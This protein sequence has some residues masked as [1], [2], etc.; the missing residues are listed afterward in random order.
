MR[1]RHRRLAVAVAL[2]LVAA[3]LG[4]AMAGTIVGKVEARSP[5]RSQ[6]AAAA[7][8]DAAYANRRYKFLERIDYD[9]LRDF[10]VSIDR[11]SHP[12]PTPAPRAVITQKDGQFSPHVLP[13]VVGTEVEWPNLD[14]IFHNVFSISDACG[15][16]LG[17][18]KRGEGAKKVRFE[19]PGRVDVF[20]SIHTKMSCIVLVLPNPWFARADERGRYV[21][22]DVPPG[23][24]RLKAW[25][26]RLPAQVKEVVVPE[27]G[28]VKVDFT[29][30]LGQQP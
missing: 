6:G 27:A 18:Y 20:C 3:T 28:E 19:L 22:K 24:Y 29:L 26:E 11:V 7:G 13:V 14:D 8:G 2:A 5:E 30:G 25:H 1:R 12:A 4:D 16:D 10:V 15:F 9:T 17:L 21:I 23:T